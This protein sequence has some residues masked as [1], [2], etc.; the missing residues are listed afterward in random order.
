MADYAIWA[1]LEKRAAADP[2]LK[3]DLDEAVRRGI[4][5]RPTAGVDDY[6]RATARGLPFVGGGMDEFS[7]GMNSLIGDGDYESNLEEE[8]SRDDWFDTAH[9][10]GSMAAK[11]GGAVLGTGVMPIK[12]LFGSVARSGATGTAMGFA[13]GFGSGEDGFENRVDNSIMPAAFGGLFGLAVPLASRGVQWLYDKARPNVGHTPAGRAAETVG[14]ATHSG[15]GEINGPLANTNAKTLALAEK[16][17]SNPKGGDYAREAIKA[18]EGLSPE[19]TGAVQ[20][21]VDKSAANFA[22]EAFAQKPLG[23][24]LGTIKSATNFQMGDV[25]ETLLRGFGG[26]LVN[27]DMDEQSVQ[28]LRLLLAKSPEAIDDIAKIMQQAASTER[29]RE[30]IGLIVRALATSTVARSAG[31]GRPTGGGGF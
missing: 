4:L 14:R 15:G 28:V 23:P 16:A 26:K 29:Q 11:T 10:Y 27:G 9:P 5:T 13:E 3:M 25:G 31:E 12:S 17:A 21:G 19:A 7:A 2:K 22:D 8:R 20:R 6:V 30:A 24:V 18:A 1:E